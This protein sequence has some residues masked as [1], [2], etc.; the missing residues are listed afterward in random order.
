MKPKIFLGTDH[1]GFKLKEAVKKFLIGEGYEVADQG[2]LFYDI[3]DD[4]PRFIAATAKKVSKTPNSKGIVFGG[5]GQGE[6]IAANKIKGIRA[7]VYYGNNM[8]IVK[9]SRLHNNANI[10]SLGARFLEE[11]QAIEAV[12]LWLN[13]PFSN[14]ERHKRRIK[15]IMQIEKTCK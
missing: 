4:Y 11:K 12:R 15:Q 3:S 8:D 6:A 7:S 14:E 5:S 2:A 13:T 1:A 10:L 9:L